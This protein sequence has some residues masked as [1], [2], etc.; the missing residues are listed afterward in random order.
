M[1]LDKDALCNEC[2]FEKIGRLDVCAAA[3]NRRN[4]DNV[5]YMSL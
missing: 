3:R 4:N 5:T 2:V 1:V